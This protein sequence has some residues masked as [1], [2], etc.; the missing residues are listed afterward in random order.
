M[1]EAYTRYADSAT[2]CH[3]RVVW[4]CLR[5]DL[6]SNKEILVLGDSYTAVLNIYFDQLGKEHGFKA[7]NITASS[8][9][10]IFPISITSALQESA[11]KACIEQIENAKKYLV[12]AQNIFLAAR[13]G[14]HLEL[15]EFKNSVIK[16]L[17]DQSLAKK[18][19]YLFEQVP[20]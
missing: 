17:E 20:K 16:F 2:I 3:G 19:I 1:L 10:A 18:N 4:E 12:A 14:L 7:R 8:C 5:G 9:V 13:W 11:R 15:V 6:S